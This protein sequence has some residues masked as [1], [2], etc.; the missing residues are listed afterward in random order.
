MR[1]AQC[2]GVALCS[3]TSAVEAEE[4]NDGGGGGALPG[5][6]LGDDPIG[7][8]KSPSTCFASL[9]C[10]FR[11]CRVSAMGYLPSFWL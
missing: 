5:N 2:R 3:E 8:R 11:I 7:S 1:L 9:L 10:C 4:N 6:G